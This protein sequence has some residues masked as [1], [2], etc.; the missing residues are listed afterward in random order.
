[1][2]EIMEIKFKFW[3][4]KSSVMYPPKT[5]KDITETMYIDKTLIPLQYT[6]FTDPKDNEVYNGD[7]LECK[8]YKYNEKSLV[9]IQKVVFEDG[10]YFL[11]TK[12][13]DTVDYECTYNY[14]QLYVVDEIKILGN[15]YEN[16][17][18]L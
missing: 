17:E 16:P 9:K 18:L 2:R 12:N 10:C 7:I 11:K 15:I 13:A 6:G 1:M 14:I 8:Y 4:T 5:L 3:C